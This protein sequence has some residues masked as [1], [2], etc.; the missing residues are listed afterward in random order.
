MG[1]CTLECEFT[2]KKP[3]NKPHCTQWVKCTLECAFTIKEATNE[4]HLSLEG[5]SKTRANS[6]KLFT[7]RPN[8]QMFLNHEICLNYE[9]LG[10]NCWTLHYSMKL[11]FTLPSVVKAL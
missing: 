6:T 11:Y 4:H 5:P 2:M 3:S 8:L 7:L 10:H 9:V 1:K